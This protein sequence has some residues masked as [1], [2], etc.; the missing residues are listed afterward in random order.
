MKHDLSLRSGKPLNPGDNKIIRWEGP[1]EELETRTAQD[2]G[3][4]LNQVRSA[5]RG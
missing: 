1:R 4:K 2:C 5:P 3:K